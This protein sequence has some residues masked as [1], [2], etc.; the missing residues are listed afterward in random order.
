MFLLWILLKL[1]HYI[2]NTDVYNIELISGIGILEMGYLI[3]DHINHLY[4]ESGNYHVSLNTDA[5][6]GYQYD[7]PNFA[8]IIID[9]IETD[10]NLNLNS[11]CN[12]GS[13]NI[14]NNSKGLSNINEYGRWKRLLYCK[15][16]T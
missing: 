4:T 14:L 11:D 16:S 8:Y 13:I 2:F 5:P 6:N 10:V 15:C 3:L 9:S 7:L 1:A 12:S